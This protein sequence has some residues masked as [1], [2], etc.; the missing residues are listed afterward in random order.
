MPTT[1]IPHRSALV[2]PEPAKAAMGKFATFYGAE[3]SADI[4]RDQSRG[5]DVESLA[6]R[7]DEESSYH[8]TVLTGTD[9]FTSYAS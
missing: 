9:A 5:L 7:N 6:S 4:G 2:Q 8:R 3:G 1:R